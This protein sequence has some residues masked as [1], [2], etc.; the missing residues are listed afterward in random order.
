MSRRAWMWVLVKYAHFWNWI[1]P[2]DTGPILLD[3]IADWL[4]DRWSAA[5]D[6]EKGMKA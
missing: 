6:R 2:K 5:Y 1:D 4:E 3:H